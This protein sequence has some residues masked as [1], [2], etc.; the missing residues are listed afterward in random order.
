[1]LICN[2]RRKYFEQ[3]GEPFALQLCGVKIYC[4]SRPEDVTNILDGSPWT[5]GLDF[6]HFIS[7][8]MQKFGMS[9]EDVRRAEYVPQP[10]DSCYIEGN[11]INPQHL[12][13]THFVEKLYKQ[14]FLEAK[15]LGPLSS[16]FFHSI[17]ETLRIENLD[18]CAKDYNGNAYSLDEDALGPRKTVG[19]FPLVAGTMVE[20]TLRA[21]FG[22]YLHQFDHDIVNQVIMFNSHA[23]MLF[24]GLPDFGGL[25]P[26][27]EPRDRIR[28]A[29]RAFVRMPED[30]RSEQCYA[31]KNLLKWMDVLG[32]GEE[33]RVGLLF[34]FFF[35]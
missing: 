2:T 12:N 17:E 20:A 24:Y 25:A 32:I 3:T 10:G 13:L 14:Q 27:C 33:S 11:D 30:Q 5:H 29:F 26:V 31:F 28:A 8:I 19:L 34:L 23:W 6:S 4:L 1:M 21:L 35:A 9:L 16:V 18:F 22:P 7:E 15:N